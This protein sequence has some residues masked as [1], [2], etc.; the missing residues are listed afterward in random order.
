M[1]L[2]GVN[3]KVKFI[4]K[5]LLISFIWQLNMII[6]NFIIVYYYIL[7]LEMQWLLSRLLFLCLYSVSCIPL[8]LF[9][10][11]P[12]CNEVFHS[13]KL[14]IKITETSS[15]IAHPGKDK[16]PSDAAVYR[17]Y[18]SLKKNQT[19]DQKLGGDGLVSFSFSIFC[20]CIF[21]TF[22]LLFWF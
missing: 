12:L 14:N 22:L 2:T 1:K 18:Y 16:G 21:F 5:K 15:N 10:F 4:N 11:L 6:Y 13:D 9:F 8:S 19:L 17:A 20:A 7:N 3:K